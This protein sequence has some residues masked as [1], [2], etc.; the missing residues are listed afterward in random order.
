MSVLG[1]LRVLSFEQYGAGPY[2]TMHLAELGADV[3]KIEKPG[4]GDIGRQVPPLQN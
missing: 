3:I 4:E 1:D 2:A